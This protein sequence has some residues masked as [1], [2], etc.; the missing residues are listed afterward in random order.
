MVGV[1]TDRSELNEIENIV[2]VFIVAERI[3]DLTCD[4]KNKEINRNNLDSSTKIDNNPMPYD[5]R[6]KSLTVK[7]LN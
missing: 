7:G 1:T 3:I 5:R 4:M 2:K 6:L